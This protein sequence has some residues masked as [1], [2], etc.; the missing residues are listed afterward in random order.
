MKKLEV[1]KSKI[2]GVG[3]HTLEPIKKGEHIAFVTG[4]LVRK[5]TKN[6]REASG[7][8]MALWYGITDT[9]WLDPAETIWRYFNHSCEPNTAIV[10]TRKVIALRNI[11][12]GEEL[13]FDYS[14][15][16]GDLNWEMKCSCKTR[17]CRKKL[18]SIQL[19]SQSAF[20]K[21]M[22]F[23]PR[24]FQMLRKKYLESVRIKA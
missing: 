6:K 22:P 1:R 19:I 15:T 3:I 5:S 14:M 10:G 8:E 20:D 16:D 23:I 13:A 9:L 11:A 21:H 2:Q 18:H 24:Y 12:R 17:T 4:K 7:R